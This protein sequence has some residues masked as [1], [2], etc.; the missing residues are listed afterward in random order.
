MLLLLLLFHYFSPI[1]SCTFVHKINFYCFSCVWFLLQLHS[2]SG[3]VLH[4]GFCIFCAPR[5]RRCTEIISSSEGRNRHFLHSAQLCESGG[6]GQCQKRNV[7]R[8][9]VQRDCIA[10]TF[11]TKNNFI[12][13]LLFFIKIFTYS[14]SILI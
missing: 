11:V 14:F 3:V 8:T 7:T 2:D 10:M 4:F 6:R 1:L 5:P 13:N 9:P 12:I